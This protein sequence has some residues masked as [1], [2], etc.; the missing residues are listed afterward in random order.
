MRR[1]PPYLDYVMEQLSTLGGISARPMFGGTGL[2]RSGLIFGIVFRDTLYFKV[3]GA[4]RGDY[5]ERGMSRFKPF[6][7]R[8][9]LSM[10]YYE[11]PPEV[12]EDGEACAAWARRAI[13]SRRAAAEICSGSAK[14]LR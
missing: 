10:S 4:T 12:L 9:T 5:Q 7:D 2:Y 1:R 8:P 14:R 11:V 6:P 13:D 3:D